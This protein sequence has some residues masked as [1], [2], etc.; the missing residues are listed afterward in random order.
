MN[1][2][3]EELVLTNEEDDLLNEALCI[4]INY[5]KNIEPKEYTKI[6]DKSKNKNS[7][8][9][10]DTL[11]DI[12]NVEVNH[13]NEK[14]EINENKSSTQ[15]TKYKDDIT[16]EI[17]QNTHKRQRDITLDTR[18]PKVSRV[19]YHSDR[20]STS[21]STNS[22]SINNTRKHVEYETDPAVLARRQKEIDYGKNTIGYDRY[23]QAV[24]KDKRTR[25]H[26]RTPPKY[27]KHSRRRWDGMIKLWRKQLH[28]WDPPQE[29]ESNN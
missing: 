6:E 3:S 4:G 23:I 8:E 26:P 9:E 15:C 20:S 12:K 28:F 19:K 16:S 2:D 7:L 21:N 14:F 10:N 11:N 27:I 18:E 22:Y 25:E 29:N 1:S 5:K 24:P 13:T 17:H